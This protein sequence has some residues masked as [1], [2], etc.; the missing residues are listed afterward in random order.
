MHCVCAPE[1]TW[2]GNHRILVTRCPTK[3]DEI[4]MAIDQHNIIIE[5]RGVARRSDDEDGQ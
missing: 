4:L 2:N 5:V 3:A 1:R